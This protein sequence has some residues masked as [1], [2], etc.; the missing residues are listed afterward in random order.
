MS[1]FNNLF[2]TTKNVVNPLNLNSD[3]RNFIKKLED[4]N[5]QEYI[6]AFDLFL[7]QNNF[8]S[9]ENLKR[10][11]QGTIKFSNGII[12]IK[13]TL[14]EDH[15]QDR[16]NFELRRKPYSG[17]NPYNEKMYRNVAGVFSFKP[18]PK[19]VDGYGVRGFG[20]CIR[21]I[22]TQGKEVFFYHEG[23]CFSSDD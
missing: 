18:L 16:I 2:N 3:Y 7:E 4:N 11:K 19:D 10:F 13:S 21:Y 14:E 15:K 17:E 5:L 9:E 8:S 12:I 6:P 1:F 20:G 22:N 23:Y